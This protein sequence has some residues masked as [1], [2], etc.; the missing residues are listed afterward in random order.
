MVLLICCGLSLLNFYLGKRSD[1][2]E[3]E[4]LVTRQS[5]GLERTTRE[6]SLGSRQSPVHGKESSMGLKRSEK[7]KLKRTALLYVNL[8]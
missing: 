5:S 3:A 2:P 8:M 1:E 7:D 4:M 6:K